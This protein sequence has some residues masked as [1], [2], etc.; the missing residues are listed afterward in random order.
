MVSTAMTITAS[1]ATTNPA[2]SPVGG[3]LDA[4]GSTVTVVVEGRGVLE[5][6]SETVAVVV[7]VDGEGVD[8][9]EHAIIA[10]VNE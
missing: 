6:S 4:G 5:G 3:G 8:V 10:V 2:T 1:R 9:T 7:V